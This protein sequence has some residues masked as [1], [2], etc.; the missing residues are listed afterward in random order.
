MSPN[1][2]ISF[3][4]FRV[5]VF[6]SSVFFSQRRVTREREPVIS[7][8]RETDKP[9]SLPRAN[10]KSNHG[11]GDDEF[12][13]FLV[14]L[15]FFRRASFV[16]ARSAAELLGQ[17]EKLQVRRRYP[18]GSLNHVVTPRLSRPELSLSFLSSS[19]SSSRKLCC[20]QY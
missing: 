16:F 13:V 15:F 6:C 10:N 1:R 4:S 18:C 9:F 20:S 12:L 7:S 19:S 11:K 8:A 3:I 2:P 5:V 17:W 14:F